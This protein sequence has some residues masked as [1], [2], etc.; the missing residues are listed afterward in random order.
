MIRLTVFFHN[1]TNMPSGLELEVLL[2]RE[3]TYIH[4]VKEWKSSNIVKFS[5]LKTC[6]KLGC[7]VKQTF[8]I[9]ATN[10][11]RTR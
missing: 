10:S 2:H 4:F 11:H 9:M 6:G 8:K 5:K 1:S 3:Y 7:S